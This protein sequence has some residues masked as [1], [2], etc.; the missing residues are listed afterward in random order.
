MT[1]ARPGRPLT[2]EGLQAYARGGGG[3]G[4]PGRRTWP[5]SAPTQTRG[6][7]ALR[8]WTTSGT[9]AQ[10]HAAARQRADAFRAQVD[11]AARTTLMVET[12]RIARGIRA[13]DRGAGPAWAP[14]GSTP[15]TCPY[16]PGGARAIDSLG[17][18]GEPD[19]DVRPTWTSSPSRPVRRP[20]RRIRGGHLVVTDPARRPPEWSTSW[21]RSTAG[22]REAAEHKATQGGRKTAL[23]GTGRPGTANERWWCTGQAD[24]G[25]HAAARCAA[26]RGKRVEDGRHQS[27]RG[28]PG[29]RPGLRTVPR[30][31]QAVAASGPAGQ[32][33]WRDRVTSDA[34]VV[35]VQNDFT[36]GG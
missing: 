1:I 13:R 18:T 2:G 8:G 22:R 10:V 7:P 27:G 26:A 11:E 6:R 17:A 34:I 21:S 9:A 36:R 28:G 20:R 24:A 31:A 23:R 29:W 30:E 25:P 16:W 5:A 15:E 12:Y 14:S 3:G 35:D 4:G 32:S 19:R 33:C